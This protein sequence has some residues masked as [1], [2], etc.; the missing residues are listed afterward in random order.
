MAARTRCGS[1]AGKTGDRQAGDVDRFGRRRGRRDQVSGQFRRQVAEATSARTSVTLGYLLDEWLAGHQ[2]EETTRTSYRV[3]I[4][5]FIKPAIGDTSLTRIAQLGARPFEQLYAELRICRRRCK[6]RTFFEHRAIG[7]M[8]VTS[9][10][11]RIMPATVRVFGPGVPRGTQWCAQ[12]RDAMGV[13]RGQP[14]GGGEAA[15][16]AAPKPDP[17]TAEEAARIVSAAWEQDV[18]WGAFIWLAF[19]TGAR[20][21]ELLGLAW[22]HLDLAAGLLTIRRNLVR[23][24]GQIVVKETKTHQMRVVSLDPGTVAILTAYKQR[25]Q[26]CCT[27]LGITLDDDT[28]VFPTH[29]TTSGTVTP[30]ASL[31]GTRR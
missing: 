27:E 29:P 26:R 5:N 22:E 13:D 17:P 11:R 28:F 8:C 15:T 3:A 4:E 30:T 24:N 6:G 10:A 2:V 20:R 21:G 16:A 25:A 7:T 9:G 14:L 31:T 12:R 23:Q 1:S 18:D 19:I